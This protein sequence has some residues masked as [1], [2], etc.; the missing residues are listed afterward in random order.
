MEYTL[1]QRVRYYHSVPGKHPL[2][3]KRPCPCPCPCPCTP[4]QG[5]TVAASIQTYGILIPGK[6]PCRPKLWVMF[7][8]PWVLT[9][10]TTVIPVC[11]WQGILFNII[12]IIIIYPW[13]AC[14]VLKEQNEDKLLQ[15]QTEKDRYQKLNHHTAGTWISIK[16]R[17]I[18]TNVL[19]LM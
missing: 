16:C 19:N 8:R 12:I 11:S 15:C 2:Q 4:F 5:V 3:G 18:T 17:K 1:N 7:K 10:D 9:R 13:H 14:S 6:C